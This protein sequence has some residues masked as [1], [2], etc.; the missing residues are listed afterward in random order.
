M[1]GSFLDNVDLP[2]HETG[3]LIS[4]QGS[5]PQWSPDGSTIA[6]L[7]QIGRDFN[8]FS[9][10]SNGG[11]EKQVTTAGVEYAGFSPLPYNLAQSAVYSWSPD[12][13]RVGYIAN[14][15]GQFGVWVI[16]V[17]DGAETLLTAATDG[18]FFYCPI[19]SP[20]GRQLAFS[21][22]KKDRDE[23]GKL[24]RGLMSIDLATNEPKLILETT[25]VI[26]L[27]GWNA[28]SSSFVVAEAS[29]DNVGLPA[30]TNLIRVSL[31]GGAETR[32]VNLKNAYFYNIFLSEDKKQ[33]AFA[34]R[35]QN[36]D[37]IWIVPLVGGTSR[38]VTDNSD[39]GHYYSRLAWLRDGNSIVF[40][41]QTRYS[42]LSKMTDIE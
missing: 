21:Y 5:L 32:I 39:S 11:G 40:G 33:I 41:E 38:R 20:D 36:M 27:I 23:S 9:V 37:N 3:H 34:A 29:Q 24:V 26:R 4:E 30:E 13:T 22:R 15:N 2:I 28:D 18:S 35:A 12:S 8:L 31:A 1:Q 19:F 16:N 6:L 14:R 42:L 7:K 10:N 25:K 17:S